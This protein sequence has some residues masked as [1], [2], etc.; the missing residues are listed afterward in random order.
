M[1]AHLPRRVFATPFILTVASA[2]APESVH[3]VSSERS[4]IV[5]K[6]G[7]ACQ[8]ESTTLFACPRGASC[9]PPPPISYDCPA[10]ITTF[11]AKVVRH[12]DGAECKVAAPDGTHEDPVPCPR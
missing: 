9:N 7:D 12:G 10:A 11:P 3:P 2:C 1:A 8:S 6:D 5:T 4:W